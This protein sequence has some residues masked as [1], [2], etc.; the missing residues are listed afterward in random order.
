MI[1]IG[2]SL[3]AILLSICGV[4]QGQAQ[5][6][7]SNDSTFVSGTPNTGRIWGYAF[8]DY[9][10]KAHS[11]ALSRGGSNQ[12]TG[13]QKNENAFAFRRVY[14]GYDYNISKK[15][16]AELL[17]AAED[18]TARRRS[19][20]DLR[21][22][23][24]VL[25]NNKY[26]FYIKYANLRIKEI[27]PGTD[28]VVGQSETPTFSNSS[29]RLWGYR[30][31]ERTITDIRRSPSYDMGVSLQGKFDPQGNYGYNL[32]VGNGSGA[33]AEQDKYKK[34]YADLW[35]KFFDQRLTV[36]L[37]TD[38]ERQQWAGDQHRSTNMVKLFVGYE[39]PKYALGAEAFINRGKNNVIGVN[40]SGRDT[41][42][43]QATGVS[44][45]GHLTLA[46]G[47]LK[48][49]ARMDL[50]NPEIKYDNERYTGYEGLLSHYDPNTKERFITAGLDFT[51]VDKLHI[52]PNIWYNGYKGQAA[53]LSGKEK[54]DYDLVYRLTFYYVFGK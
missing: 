6:F 12:Y 44:F 40:N 53:G 20:S 29:Q 47:K 48:A 52:M 50:L 38:Y 36:D 18:N 37:Y 51:P 33:V 45:F 14:L 26:S 42:N 22:S 24:D 46:P 21:P 11:D 39:R 13:I 30:S 4:Y 54:S 7:T 31:V 43:Q 8:G 3:T 25:S 27:W 41:L 2:R 49:F 17:L 1:R 34:F 15:F 23:G 32:M 28:L 5:I 9:Y 35:A 19:G 16:S 10:M